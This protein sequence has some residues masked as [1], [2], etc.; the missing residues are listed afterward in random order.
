MGTTKDKIEKSKLNNKVNDSFEGI[1][2]FVIKLN[3]CFILV[4]GSEK[5]WNN[6]QQNYQGKRKQN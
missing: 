1:S 4:L 5:E 3:I 6:N 2:S